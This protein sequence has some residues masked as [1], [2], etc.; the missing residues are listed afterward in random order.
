MDIFSCLPSAKLSPSSATTLFSVLPCPDSSACTR[1]Y[2]LIIL[3]ILCLI[4]L[5]VN[6]WRFS[7]Q[8]NYQVIEEQDLSQ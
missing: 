6:R 8:T 5:Y 2:L 3:F 1:F 7:S 4:L